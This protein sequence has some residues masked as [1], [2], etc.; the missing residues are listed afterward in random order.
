MEDREGR[1]GDRSD[2]PSQV[3]IVSDTHLPAEGPSVPDR[4]A[5]EFEAADHVLH[6]GDFLTPQARFELRVLAGGEMTAVQGNRDPSLPLPE[7]AT[8][9]TAG[10]RF[11]LTHG[12]DLG[13]GDAYRD[14]LAALA[15][16]YDADVAVGGH[17]HT[18]LD[19]TV[20]GVR[21]LNPG[22]ATGAPPADRPTLLTVHCE[23]GSVRVDVRD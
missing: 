21:V 11:V 8:Y 15:G 22:S 18:L 17:T 6:A 10:V 7:V 3:A 2:R 14:G 19:A 9:E 5:A 12:D 20:D 1:V 13:R 4:F 16:E 23:D